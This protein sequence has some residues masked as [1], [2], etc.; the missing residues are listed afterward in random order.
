MLRLQKTILR[1]SDLPP[2]GTAVETASLEFKGRIPEPL[3]E[4][5]VRELAKD[6]AALANSAGGTIVVGAF[7][8]GGRLG[9]YKPMDRQR[10]GHVKDAYE[11][12]LRDLCSPAPVINV[13][14]IP[15]EPPDGLLVAVNV[16]AFP[17]GP[18]G[19]LWEKSGQAYSFP[20]RTGTHT[21]WLRPEQLSMLMIPE[22]RRVA[23]LIDAIP[24]EERGSVLVSGPTRGDPSNPYNILVRVEDVDIAGN[25]LAMTYLDPGGHKPFLVPLDEVQTVWRSSDAW[26]IVVRGNIAVKGTWVVYI[27]LMGVGSG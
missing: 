26:R 16:L 20:L 8:N 5:D 24:L 3:E 17:V 22:L 6:V 1:Q 27:P 7:E 13:Y 14:L 2:M 25:R 12:A 18:V 9:V 15:Y 11:R 4:S 23:I 21:Q 19:I 10:A